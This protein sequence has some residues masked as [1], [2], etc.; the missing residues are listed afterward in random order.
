MPKDAARQFLKYLEEH[1]E[2]RKRLYDKV[3]TE[4]AEAGRQLGFEFTASELGELLSE[5]TTVTRHV[6]AWGIL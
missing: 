4:L 2:V 1:P 3:D 5:E 6:R